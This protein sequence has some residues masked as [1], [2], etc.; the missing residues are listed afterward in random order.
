MVII[1][2]H[3]CMSVNDFIVIRS[4]MSVMSVDAFIEICSC[5]SLIS[6]NCQ[7]L[8][9][10]VVCVLANRWQVSLGITMTAALRG[11]A[12]WLLGQT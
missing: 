3:S 4:C 2:I 9:S 10:L 6:I 7:S 12:F 11:S 8:L 5:M 1:E